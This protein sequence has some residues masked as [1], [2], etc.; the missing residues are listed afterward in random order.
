MPK[1]GSAPK[2]KPSTPTPSQKKPTVS[3]P[4][5]VWKNATYG[6]RCAENGSPQVIQTKGRIAGGVFGLNKDPDQK[7]YSG[8][9]LTHLPTGLAIVALPEEKDI[10]FIAEYMYKN[11]VKDLISDDKEDIRAA[12]PLWTTQWL[13]A[14]HDQDKLLDPAEFEKESN[15]MDILF[16]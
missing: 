5:L 16:S 3:K 6:I 13:K 7:K 10:V 4:Q 11:H 12:I 1:I 9:C 8:W 14:C 2:K 15:P